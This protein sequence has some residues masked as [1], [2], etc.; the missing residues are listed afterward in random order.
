MR[1]PSFDSDPEAM[2]FDPVDVC[3]HPRTIQRGV[4]VTRMWAQR[5]CSLF[6][7]IERASGN[8][9]GRVGPWIPDRHI[10]TEI[11]WAI[12]RPSWGNGYAVEAAVARG[13][14]GHSSARMD[15]SNP[16]MD[17]PDPPP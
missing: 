14:H 5:G 9:V 7:V 2:R 8:W 11:G 10:G 4:A 16:F 15:R 6:S 17:A 13:S 1:G 12:A 3:G